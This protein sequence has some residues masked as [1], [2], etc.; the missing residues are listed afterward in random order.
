MTTK[1]LAPHFLRL[2]REI[3]CDEQAAWR[4]L[5]DMYEMRAWW[6]MPVCD[7]KPDVGGGFELRYIGRD[8]VDHFEYSTW[9]ENWR[10]GGTW[11][12]NWLRGTVQ[13]LV[14]ITPF[15]HG[16][17]VAIEQTNFE[18]F[19]ANA[20]R[21]FGYHKIEA[22]SRLERLQAWCERRMPANLAQ[23]PVI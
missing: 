18:S 3:A 1:V 2:E 15:E 23:M 19:G 6:G 5:T 17:R 16:V 7:H 21:I 14:I 13:E 4:A 8:R 12:Y 11:A 20:S 10:V 22:A 9:D